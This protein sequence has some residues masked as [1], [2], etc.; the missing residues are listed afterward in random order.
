M[1]ENMPVYYISQSKMKT[2]EKSICHLDVQFIFRSGY[3]MFPQNVKKCQT[4]CRFFSSFSIGSK[5]C[6]L[7]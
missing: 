5:I 6:R 3:D 7:A 4:Y 1:N 2:L